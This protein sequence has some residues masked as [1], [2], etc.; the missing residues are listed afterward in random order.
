MAEGKDQEKTE[1]ATPKRREKARKEGQVAQSREIPSVLVL[2]SVLGFF[3]LSGFYLFQKMSVLMR[4]VFQRV[5][6][7]DL[8]AATAGALFSEILQYIFI[9]LI[10]VML[11]VIVAGLTG[12][13]FQVGLMLSSKPMAPKLSKLNPLS[14][15]K[16]L[17][18][19][20]SMIELVKSVFKISI[21]GGVAYLM[22]RGEL[23]SIPALVQMDIIEILTFIGR[24]S[25]RILFYTCLVL[26]L[27]AALDYAYQKWQYEK[28]MRMTK[29]EVKDEA[30]QSQGDPAVRSRIKSIQRE[31]AQRRM[32]DSV[33]LADVIITN[34]TH[35]AV[36]IKY[37]DSMTAPEVIAKGAGFIAERIKRIAQEKG[38]PIV[39]NK[40]LAQTLFKVVEIGDVIPF[41]LYRA[42]AEILAYVYRLKGDP[43]Y[44][45]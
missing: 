8:Q 40:P 42:V 24:V 3:S 13:I 36:A 12:N 23:Q 9:L 20:R 22:V 16:K 34:P 17:V 29:Q 37:D 2:L 39:E 6:S 10:P 35:L 4:Y 19:L 41:N 5:A 45:A 33:P 21:V 15:L 30:K 43:R 1:K 14:G 31:M 32:M 26:I 18:S 25:F 38:I 7:F 11:V 27:L 44:R 28:D